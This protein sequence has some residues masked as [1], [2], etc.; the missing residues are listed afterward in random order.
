MLLR[1]KRPEQILSADTEDV[2]IDVLPRGMASGKPVVVLWSSVEGGS[3]VVGTQLTADNFMGLSALR[4][5][6]GKMIESLPVPQLALDGC[7][8]IAMERVDAIMKGHSEEMDDAL[9]DGQLT[10][11]AALMLLREVF[12]TLAVEATEGVDPFSLK[13]AIHAWSKHRLNR[14]KFLSIVG[15]FIAAEIERLRR[16][17]LQ[18]RREA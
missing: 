16:I 10:G 8:M 6:V 14:V 3:L 11:I 13:C 5:H 2:G 18:R 4:R 12:P 1:G 9:H 15:Q 17:E 7:D